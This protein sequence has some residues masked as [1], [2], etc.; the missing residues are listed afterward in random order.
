M[1]NS[2]LAAKRAALRVDQNTFSISRLRNNR[3]LKWIQSKAKR[4]S[5]FLYILYRRRMLPS[6]GIKSIARAGFRY[7]AKWQRHQQRIEKVVVVVVGL[8]NTWVHI[9]EEKRWNIRV[10]AL[11]TSRL[12]MVIEESFTL[13]VLVLLFTYT[14]IRERATFSL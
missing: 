11:S 3:T 9:E 13:Q 14:C 10:Y 4:L 12:C 1:P 8:R 6:I 7:F 5:L 2:E